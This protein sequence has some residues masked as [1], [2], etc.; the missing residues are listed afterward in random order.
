MKYSYIRFSCALLVQMRNQELNY[1]K[2][3]T[4]GKEL[5]DHRPIDL[6][7]I[8]KNGC[9][10]PEKFVSISWPFLSTQGKPEN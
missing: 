3:V 10:I 7:N 5:S 2:T 1:K 4:K 8:A 6:I 9:S